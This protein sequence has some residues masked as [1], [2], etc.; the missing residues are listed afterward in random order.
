MGKPY[1]MRWGG[2]KSNSISVPWTDSLGSISSACLQNK[3]WKQRLP[4]T[5]CICIKEN[6]QDINEVQ[7]C[8]TPSK[9]CSQQRRARRYSCNVSPFP[10]WGGK[11]CLGQSLKAL[12]TADVPLSD[13]SQLPPK[14]F[15]MLGNKCSTHCLSE[16]WWAMC[17]QKK[18]AIPSPFQ[19]ISFSVRY[20]TCFTSYYK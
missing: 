7:T 18:S 8:C 17:L 20:F 12:C 10:A 6:E 9:L 11:R 1:C 14:H 16:G 4:W 3:G 2:W 19:A 5:S 13:C 15:W